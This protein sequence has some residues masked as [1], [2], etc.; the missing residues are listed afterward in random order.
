MDG[1]TFS[2]ELAKMG[3]SIT[4][5]HFSVCLSLE[6][7]LA[8]HHHFVIVVYVTA[9]VVVTGYPPQICESN[10]WN[11]WNLECK[12]YDLHQAII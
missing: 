5:A 4:C 11:S 2:G 9:A 10:S 8:P 12:N 1:T 6:S 3:R 7:L